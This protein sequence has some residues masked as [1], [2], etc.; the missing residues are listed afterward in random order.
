MS[1]G[2]HLIIDTTPLCFLQQLKVKAIAP[3]I[4]IRNSSASNAEY[5]LLELLSTYP[6][7]H[8]GFVSLQPMSLQTR[9]M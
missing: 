1:L 3:G 6:F 7:F 5:H 2:R 9:E 8:S 4:S